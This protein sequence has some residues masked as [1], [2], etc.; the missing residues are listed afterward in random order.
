MHDVSQGCPVA[1]FEWANVQDQHTQKPRNSSIP[2]R[3]LPRESPAHNFTIPEKVL[4]TSD[5]EVAPRYDAEET[6]EGGGVRAM[7]GT[8]ASSPECHPGCL[9]G[10]RWCPR[11]GP[12]CRSPT[13]LAL[14][15]A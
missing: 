3:K 10:R 6:R 8:P 12:P 15:A 14:C 4:Q 13:L 7:T 2:D 1:A 11:R 5:T 9:L